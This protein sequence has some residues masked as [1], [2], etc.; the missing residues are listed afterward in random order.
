VIPASTDIS[1][2]IERY[3]ALFF[4]S[5]GVLVDGVDALPG[6]VE[7]VKGMNAESVNYFVVPNDASKSMASRIE[8]FNSQGFDI[9]A[10]R[11]I[12]SGSL[13]AGYFEQHD[14]EGSPTLVLGT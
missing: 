5:F 4:D 13:I 2:L 9:Q 3:D 8:T 11:I 6:A 7:L 10:E 12:N 14:L 1:S